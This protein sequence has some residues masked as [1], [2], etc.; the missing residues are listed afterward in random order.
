MTVAKLRS[1]AIGVIA[2]SAAALS[3]GC[4]L[5]PDARANPTYEAD[6]LPIFRSRCLRC[7]GYPP[8]GDPDSIV[9]SPPPASPR[10]DV[11]GDTNCGADAAAATCI[12]GAGFAAMGKLFKP[13]LVNSDQKSGGMPPYPA[14]ALTSYQ[15]DTILKWEDETPPLEK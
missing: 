14:P 13:V 9:T 15:V 8:L 12:R 1:L 4:N 6:V 11:F 5:E 2:L 10:F 3:A 7:H